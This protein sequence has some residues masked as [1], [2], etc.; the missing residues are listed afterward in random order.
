MEQVVFDPSS[1]PHNRYNPLKGE[2]VLVCPHR[3]KRPWAGQIEK[4]QREKVPEHDPNNPLCPGATRS[5]GQV[6][7]MYESTFVFNNDFPAL[8]KDCPDPPSSENPLFQMTP[9]RGQ[10]RVIC[11]HPRSDLTLPLMKVEDIRR[12]VDEWCKQLEDLG[13]TNTWVQI[14]ENKGNVMGC[15][16]PHPHCQ[17]WASSFLPAEPFKSDANQ[18]AYYRQH[19]RPMLVDYVKQEIEKKERIVVENENWIAIVP[20]WALWPFETILFPKRHVLRLTDL[21][22]QEKNSLSDIMKRLLVKYDNLFECSFPYSMGWHGA[23]T[24]DRLKENCEHWQLHALYYPPLVRSASVKKFMVG[25]EMLAQAQ[26]DLT[27][28]QAAERLRN[29][30]EEHYTLSPPKD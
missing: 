10:C 7:P 22:E 4:K 18:L 12:V 28:E 30:S 26:R 13:H 21:T 6:N 11:F 14:F 1:H 8:L 17:V 5:N 20:F 23:P 3:L 9:A 16:N 29:L 2:W 27:A 24:G 19:G 15:S 25:F